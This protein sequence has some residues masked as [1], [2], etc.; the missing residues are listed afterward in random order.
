MGS[1]ES[2]TLGY[3]TQTLC[4]NPDSKRAFLEITIKPVWIIEHEN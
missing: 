4:K 1:N 3:P 2:A